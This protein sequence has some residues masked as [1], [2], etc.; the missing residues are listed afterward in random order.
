[1]AT[2]RA[3]FLTLSIV[4]LAAAAP[5]ESEHVIRVDHYVPVHSAVPAIQGQTTA[6]YVRE[7]V[8]PGTLA[9]ERALGD[10]VVL[11]IHGAGTPAEVA[12]DVNYEDYSWMAFLAKAGLDAFGMDMTGYGR[13]TRPAPM[14][15]PCNLSKDQQAGFVPGLIAAPCPASYDR[16]MTTLASDWNDIGAVVDHL[17]ALRHVER[18]NLVSWS[19]GGPRAA[20]W[21]GL[22]QDKIRRMVLLAPAYNRSAR[23]D[24]P[25]QVPA[26]GAS[27]TTQS[28]AEFSANWDRQAGCPNQ[29]DPAA[30][31]AV[32]SAMLESDPVG[33][34]W[35]TGVRRAPS[36]TSW[37]W[38]Q[39]VAQATKLPTL[40]V[41]GQHDKQVS[42]DSVRNLHA[43]LGAAQKVFVDL[44][45]SSHNALW[46]RNHLLLFRASLDWLT[47][48]AV[49]GTE[50]GIVKLGY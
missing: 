38:T 40:M 17:L 37:G 19:L 34:T 5:P 4:A 50:S 43:D 27:M 16:Q 1:M 46:E 3:S 11:F 14:N 2:R 36:V 9:R 45:C 47:K 48:G 33:A 22:H 35:G 23:A 49:N 13:S 41:S 44:A 10:K 42:P 26:A 20:G 29:Y 31:E 12:F 18:V 39:A 7:V 21:A 15:D 8:L 25:A 6:I 30:S 32:W 28:H 24:P